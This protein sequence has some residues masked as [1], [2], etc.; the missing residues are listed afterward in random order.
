M[1]ILK[2]LLKICQVLVVKLATL[3]SHPKPQ[4]NVAA[5]YLALP[6]HH[7]IMESKIAMIKE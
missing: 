6:A 7:P 5:P 4:P 1:L 3:A 2:E